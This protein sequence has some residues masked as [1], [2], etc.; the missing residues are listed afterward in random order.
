M[1]IYKRRGA[2]EGENMAE[3]ARRTTLTEGTLRG[4]AYIQQ[5]RFLTIAQF[6]RIAGISTYHAGQVLQALETHPYATQP[7]RAFIRG[8][9]LRSSRHGGTGRRDSRTPLPPPRA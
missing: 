5:Y 3:K 8:S 9:R 2:A 6:A 4:L 7:N 1:E